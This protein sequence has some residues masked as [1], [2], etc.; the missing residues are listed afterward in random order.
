MA[1]QVRTTFTDDINGADAVETV[2]F[3][4]DGNHYEIDLDE[5]NAVALRKLL[6]TYAEIGR[7][8]QHVQGCKPASLPAVQAK[9]TPTKQRGGTRRRIAS[10]EE[11]EAIK[12]S[13]AVQE[14]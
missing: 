8:V 2:I 13:R 7:I 9:A 12:A 5:Q 4:M 11:I 3:A 1:R 10:M 6:A 14:R